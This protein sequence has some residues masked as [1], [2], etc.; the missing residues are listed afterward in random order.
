MSQPKHTLVIVESPAKA[1]TLSK[2]LGRNYR[3]EASQ[4]HVRDLPKSRLGIDPEND[5]ELKY[6]TIR[7]RGEILARIRKEAKNAK[8]VLLATDPDREGEAISWHLANILNI[9][10]ESNCRIEAHEI[11]K[12]AVAVAVKN[13]RPVNMN[14]VDAQ[15]ARRALDRLV[16]YQISPILWKKV[17]KGLSAG[18]VQSVAARLIVDRENEINDFVPEEYWDI[19]AALKLKVGK[20]NVTF[21]AK[22][23][24]L[25]G[26]KADVTNQK[27]AEEAKK[28]IE[29]AD[30]TV[31]SVKLGQRKKSPAPPFT[32]STLQQE[33]GRKLNFT[34]ARTMQVVQTL[35]EGVDVPGEGLQGL[36]TYIRTDS[37]RVSNEALAMVRD[38]IPKTYGSEYMP[39]KPRV[40]KG[41]STAQDA[42]EAIRPTSLSR[43][44]ESLKPALT[45]DQHLLYRLIYNRFVSSQM[46]DARYENMTIL[47]DCPG[48]TLRYYGENKVFAGFTAVYEEGTDDEDAIKPQALPTTEEGMIVKA[49]EVTAEQRFTQPAARY[50]EASLIKALEENGIGRPSTYAPTIATIISRGYVS[51]EKKRLYPTELGF[52]VTKVM[53]EYFPPIVDVDFTAQM[54]TELDKVE[55]GDLEWKEVLRAFYPSFEEMLKEAE[56]QMEKIEIKDEVSDVPCD[57]C[58][59]TMVYKNGRYGP[60]LACPNFPDCR[61]TKPILKYI[62]VPCPKCG[63]EVLEK[64]SKRNRKFFGCEQYPD[65]DF[66]SWEKPLKDRCPKCGAYMT[67]KYRKK[68]DSLK[69][70]ANETCRYHEP[71][72]EL[73]DE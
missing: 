7:G 1:R 51:R 67:Y 37:V 6:I 28:L 47:F 35:Y 56:T 38:Y 16:G 62:G 34:S 12:S 10:P 49:D 30:L 57:K 44:P 21:Q 42:H 18:R 25:N 64:I 73:E 52:I 72:Q 36:V 11:T 50:T 63:G 59:A 60:F 69:I 43:T 32:T 3:I 29:N 8:K 45:R 24:R 58:G 15:Q 33:A 4:G 14:L 41:R 22:L 55:E 31:S 53:T 71:Y 20:K 17:R 9:D 13:P 61:N 48:A 66:V 54:E 39:A 26:K 5:F 27:Q 68:G 70:C 23:H 2:M 65:C 46:T 40:Y 19:Y